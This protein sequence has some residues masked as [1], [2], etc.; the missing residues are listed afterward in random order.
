MEPENYEGWRVKVLEEGGKEGWVL[1]RPSLH[2]PGAPPRMLARR[3]RGSGEGLPPIAPPPPP[4]ADI[5]LNV[6]SEQLGGVRVILTHLLDFFKANPGFQVGLKTGARACASRPAPPSPCLTSTAPPL[7]AQVC[8]GKVEV[9]DA[10]TQGARAWLAC[11]QRACG[12]PGH[13][14]ARER[15]P[16]HPRL[17]VRPRVAQDYCF[18]VEA[19]AAAS[20]N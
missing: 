8:T 20:R 3:A 4:F 14:P 11:S 9:S 7:A 12:K 6:E 16:A 5:V 17:T 2:D 13:P 10:C 15:P 1:L 18:G 19:Q